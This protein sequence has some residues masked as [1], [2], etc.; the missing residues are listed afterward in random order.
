MKH[1]NATRPLPLSQP[2]P[3]ALPR[4]ARCRVDVLG[5]LAAIPGL[6]CNDDVRELLARRSPDE[7]ARLLLDLSGGHVDASTA[8]PWT[9]PGWPPAV[10]VA[11]LL[12]VLPTWS[13][14]AVCEALAR[15]EAEQL[16]RNCDR[17]RT[18][19][20]AWAV[21]L[22]PTGAEAAR[23]L[24]STPRPPRDPETI[25]AELRAVLDEAT[26]EQRARDLA[27]LHA[28]DKKGGAA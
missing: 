6:P 5:A 18:I 12:R 25:L 2:A 7:A 16:V 23:A 4:H 27:A 21:Q 20:R 24:R 19:R 9:D 8:W 26:P 3:L 22:T 1:R 28:L 10:D 11:S 14:A 15:L 17:A 13:R